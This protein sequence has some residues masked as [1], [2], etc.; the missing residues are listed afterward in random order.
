MD[1]LSFV[2]EEKALLISPAGYGKTYTIVECLKY[3]EGTQLILTHTHA[4][5]ASIKEKIKS[6]NIATHRYHVETISS[7]CQKYV[8]S[9]DVGIDL[10]DQ[11]DKRY[12]SFVL[13]KAHALFKTKLLQGVLKKTYTGLFVDEYQDCTK[14][15]HEIMMILSGIFPTR[16]LGDPLQSIFDF[17][18]DLVDFETDLPNFTRYPELAAPNRW[19]KS[20]HNALGDIIKRYRQNLVNKEPII[21]AA[22]NPNGFHV[23]KIDGGLYSDKS[24]YLKKLIQIIANQNANPTLE[25]LLILVPEYEETS[26]DGRKINHGNIAQR[27]RLKARID[28][29]NQ[30]A[31]LEAIDDR[32]FYSIAKKADT[33]INEISN[34]QNKINTVKTAILEIIYKKTGVGRWFNNGGFIN[35]R[36]DTDKK[37]LAFVKKRFENFFETP[38]PVNLLFLLE[39]TKKQFGLRQKR[40]GIYYSYLSSLKQ[41]D[42]ENIT[43][44][45]AMKDNRNR[46]RRS[47]RKVHGKCLGT[48][49]LTKG[50]EFDTVVLLDAD[51]FDSPEHLY[52]ALSRC[53]K[54]L[55]IFTQTLTLSPY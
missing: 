6:E 27:V 4:G 36:R 3:T 53:C 31:L 15:Q 9:F 8:L 49:L 13:E 40:D 11:E 39:E 17:N 42:I 23:F 50:L 45:D 5:V 51:K 37:K 2:S 20:G 10:P 41:A 21:L 38:N 19:Y 1:Y 25:S 33:L 44:Y 35:K 43:V 18:G 48:T 47:G 52:V 26:E 46:I 14:N 16:I 28:F 55:I 12:H 22:D 7:F 32:L 29:G 24:N 34:A 30:L 54:K